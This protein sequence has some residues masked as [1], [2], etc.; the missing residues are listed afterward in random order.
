MKIIQGFDQVATGKAGGAPDLAKRPTAH[1][2]DETA[3]AA[4][5]A[6]SISELSRQLNAI[7]ARIADGGFDAGRVEEIRQAIAEGRFRVNADA[8][9]DNLLKGV[10][11]LLSRSR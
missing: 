3:G 7:E 1:K 11:E 4:R 10:A 6:V 9:A 8:V 5:D 2:A